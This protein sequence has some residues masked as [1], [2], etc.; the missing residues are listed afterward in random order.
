MT[1]ARRRWGP[2]GRGSGAGSRR[3]HTARTAGPPCCVD[4]RRTRLRS[5]CRSS[6]TWPGRSGT[7]WSAGYTRT[8]RSKSHIYCWGSFLVKMCISRSEI[9]GRVC[10]RTLAGVA[11]SALGGFPRQIAVK[12]LTALTVQSLGVVITHTAAMDLHTQNKATSSAVP[13]DYL[14]QSS[15]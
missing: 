5:C 4:S 3:A 15:I 12:V 2:S 1:H 10:V 7:M 8:L 9:Y 14:T 6:C 11:V 13:E